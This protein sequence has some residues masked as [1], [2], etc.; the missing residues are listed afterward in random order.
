M[1]RKLI[2]RPV[3][4]V[5]NFFRCSFENFFIISLNFVLIFLLELSDLQGVIYL[6]SII[7]SLFFLISKRKFEYFFKLSMS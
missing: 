3:F 2:K 5:V 4:W 7:L 1:T 6:Y